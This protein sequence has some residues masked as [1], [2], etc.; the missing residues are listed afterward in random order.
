MGLRRHKPDCV[1]MFEPYLEFMRAIEVYNAERTKI[2]KKDKDIEVHLLI[3]DESSEYY[4]YMNTVETEK[5]GFQKLIEAKS[6]LY[7][8]LKDYKLE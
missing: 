2:Y 1:I 8:E 6:K 7:I 5:T 4:Q 3:Y